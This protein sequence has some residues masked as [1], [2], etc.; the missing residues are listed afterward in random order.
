MSFSL[1]SGVTKH[2]GLDFKKK[3]IHSPLLS[4]NVS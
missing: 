3:I 2:L 4:D 1:E